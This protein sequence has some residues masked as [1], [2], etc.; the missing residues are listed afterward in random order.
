MNY[1]RPPISAGANTT[2]SNRSSQST[3]QT[4]E[5]ENGSSG[6]GKDFLTPKST[7]KMPKNSIR[8]P[9]SSV[10][11]HQ[12]KRSFNYHLSSNQLDYFT[13]N[14]FSRSF[15]SL[16]LDDIKDELAASSKKPINKSPPFNVKHDYYDD[17]DSINDCIE[18]EDEPVAYGSDINDTRA[19]DDGTNDFEHSQTYQ[20]P[21][22]KEIKPKK[23]FRREGAHNDSMEPDASSSSQQSSIKRSFKFLNLSIDSSNKALDLY[24]TG[25]NKILED[26]V[27]YISDLNEIGAPLDKSPV[28]S[29]YDV[30]TATHSPIDTYSP[31]ES[32]TPLNKFKRP[33]QLVS[34]SPSPS[35]LKYL[36]SK[37]SFYTQNQHHSQNESLSN[38]IS[39]S[40]QTSLP[41]SGSN[42][43]LNLNSY[44]NS[45]SITVNVDQAPST[46]SAPPSTLNK[47]SVYSPSKLGGKGFKMFK[48]AEKNA[49]ISP[50]R[51]ISRPEFSNPEIPNHEVNPDN[52]LTR[53]S[54]SLGIFESSKL[55]SL[56]ASYKQAIRSKKLIPTSNKLRKTNSIKSPFT[57]TDLLPNYSSNLGFEYYNLDNLDIMDLEDDSPSKTKKI[58][59]SASANSATSAIQIH[60][61]TEAELLKNRKKLKNYELNKDPLY[62]DDKEN[63]A[64]SKNLLKKASYQFVKPL[65]TAFRSTGLVKKNS[66]NHNLNDASQRKLPPET[67]IKRHPMAPLDT[68]S[69]NIHNTSPIGNSNI[70]EFKASTLSNVVSSAHDETNTFDDNLE[71]SIEVGRNVSQVSNND[72]ST[73]FF[74]ISSAQGSS[75]NLLL[76]TDNDLDIDL[77][78]DDI[79]PETPTKSVKKSHSIPANFSPISYNN[80]S[81][82]NATKTKLD[83]LKKSKHLNIEP[84]TPRYHLHNTSL[85]IGKSSSSSNMLESI[86]SSQQ[87]LCN[88]ISEPTRVDDHLMNK[89]GMKNIKYLGSGEFSIA[90]ECSFQ[91]QKFAIKKTKK[92]VYGKLERSAIIREIEALRVLSS[93]KDNEMVNLQEQDEGKENLVYFIE[94]WDFNNYFYIMTEYCEGGTLFDFLEEHKNYKLDEFRIWKILIEIL[95]GL[96]FIHLKN[97]L[98]LD[99]K[100]ANIFITFEGYLK[101]GDFGLAT[102]LP[103]LEKDFD[104]EG[105]RNYIAPELIND[106]IYT[107]FADI[108]SVGLII[109]EIA[110]NIILPDNGSPWRKLRSGDLSDAGKL[111]SDNIS[112]FL[113]HQNFSSLTSYNSSDSLLHHSHLQ[114]KQYQHLQNHHQHHQLFRKIDVKHLIPSWAPEFLVSKDTN[115]LDKLVSNMLKPNPFDRP[116]TKMILES[117]ECTIIENRRKAGA[118]IFEGEFGPGDDD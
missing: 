63:D 54:T 100:P 97:Y 8:T 43:F 23:L 16:I 33:H 94:A 101:I 95:N 58:P 46:T 42:S 111:S 1:Q 9:K 70:K 45:N 56:S 96:K 91:D 76:N 73:S 112:D 60:Q 47:T 78:L 53:P 50:N 107:P 74:K 80:L 48:N 34:Q 22:L 65:Q 14:H 89:F 81:S 32:K 87:T 7:A 82:V 31:R 49:I 57:A 68:A 114:H 37:H 44:F 61:D 99:L 110:A 59:K 21:T 55:L 62:N 113:Q 116:N 30:Q 69:T 41:N 66:V 10:K 52:D 17:N 2:P 51:S 108:F 12:A 4:S 79:I 93:V 27:D 11:T 71:L 106:K 83:S 85:N 6:G 75:K 13:N 72:S 88:E 86:S 19:D 98:H 18:D 20:S 92:P 102:K 103:I 40:I 24:S 115:S 84:S 5:Q 36:T 67:P 118:T 3:T 117:E 26:D 39:N 25:N 38:S 29:K 28:A 104:L 109:L 15:N 90:Y 77:E 105:D 64:S 35:T